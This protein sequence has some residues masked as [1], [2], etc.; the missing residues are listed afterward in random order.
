V[1]GDVAIVKVENE[2][3]DTEQEQ[4]ATPQQVTAAFES[5]FNED[6]DGPATETPP[7]A[8]PAPTPAPQPTPAPTPAPEFVQ[9]TRQDW[10]RVTASA[11]EVETIKAT[12]GKM[13]DQIYGTMGR[14]L[15]RRLADLQQAT[16]Q[17]AAVEVSDEDIAELKG[18][19]PEIGELTGKV[20]KKVFAKFKGTGKAVD[21]KMIDNVVKNRTI[22]LTLDSIL[23]RDWRKECKTETGFTPQFGAWFNAQPAEV[24]QLAN[25]EGLGDAA[26]MMRLYK[27]HLDAPKPT[28]APTPTPTPVPTP[29]PSAQPSMRSRQMAAAVAPRG[30][31]SAPAPQGKTPFQEGFDAED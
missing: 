29:A 19:Y 9:V 21:E 20:L 30:E 2:T 26:K 27:A 25:S 13:P 10:E 11:A 14:T 6:E 16:P 8:T 1:Y 5:G 3:Q 15:D 18:E 7:A 31:A 22:D 17:G 12:L 24:Q 23:E 4:E 28:P